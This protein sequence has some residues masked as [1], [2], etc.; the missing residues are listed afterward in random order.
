ML[1]NIPSPTPNLILTPGYFIFNATTDGAAATKSPTP[2]I[3]PTKIDFGF[4]HEWEIPNH[5]LKAER[6]IALNQSSEMLDK[7]ERS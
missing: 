2:P 5:F 1:K 7:S 6:I 3:N 4:S